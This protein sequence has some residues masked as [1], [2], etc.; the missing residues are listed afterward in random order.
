MGETRRSNGFV[1]SVKVVLMSVA[2]WAALIAFAAAE[3]ITSFDVEY[4]VKADNT[5]TVTETIVYDFGSLQRR[6]IFREVL[7]VHPQSASAWYKTRSVGIHP[8][9][10]TRNGQTERYVN[11]ANQGMF[12]R[13]GDP[14][15]YITGA[16]EY[17]ITYVLEGALSQYEDGHTELYWNVTGSDWSVPIN[18]VSVSVRTEGGVLLLPEHACYTGPS[19]STRACDDKVILGSGART[20]A[21]FVEGGLRPGE[22]LTI[23]QA[24]NPVQPVQPLERWRWV[25]F[26][27]ALP[28]LVFF[29]LAVRVYVWRTRYRRR[30]S[31]ITQFE[32]YGAMKPMFTGVLFDNRLDPR[33]L[34]SGLVYLAQQGF[35]RVTHRQEEHFGILKSDDYEVTLLRP[36]SEVENEFQKALL[37]LLFYGQEGMI[38]RAAGL[39][40]ESSVAGLEVGK[41]VRL[42][43]LKRSNKKRRI[44]AVIYQQLKRTIKQELIDLGYVE[45]RSAF[46]MMLYLILSGIGF[47][48]FAPAFLFDVNPWLGA[49]SILLSIGSFFL[50]AFATERRTEPGYSALN[51]LKGFKRFLSVTEKERYAFHNAP[52]KSPQ[53]FMANLP[54][55]IAFGV[56]KE[57]ADAFKD[58]PLNAPEWYHSDVPGSTFNAVALTQDIGSFSDAFSTTTR[59]QSSGSSGSSGGGFSGGG[60][61]GGGGGSW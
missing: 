9:S 41:A 12:L 11:E 45:Q 46:G 37:E 5:V 38:E 30:E 13:I 18:D 8:V 25:P 34:T 49:G 28:V 51:H 61:G 17:R 35:I 6:G 39:T 1:R 21:R 59:P 29:V 53:Q 43:A 27:A 33:D 10:V 60:G 24:V 22:Q 55:A 48:V 19:G 3:S 20:E 23:G 26:L 36:V 32:P 58:I 7:P 4:V 40:E 47:F 15:V 50:L 2:L 31:I 42:S 52:Q 16:H 54:Y 44:N 14:N 56:E 57:W